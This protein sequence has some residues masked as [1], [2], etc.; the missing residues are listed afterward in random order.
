MIES[1]FRR[2]AGLP[3]KLERLDEAASGRV[4]GADLRAALPRLLRSGELA[5]VKKAWGEKLYYIPPGRLP[6]LWEQIELAA[7]QPHDDGSVH[8]HKE[9]GPG[10]ALDLFRALTWIARNGLPVTSKGT[11]HQKSVGKLTAYLYLQVGDIAGLGLRYPHQEVYPP[12]LAVVLDLLQALGLLAKER[13]SWGLDSKALTAWL[14]LEP[15]MMD[16]VL[17]RELLHRYIPDDA[18]IQ[19][20]VYRL[21]RRDLQVGS[22][23]SLEDIYVSLQGMR[24]LPENVPDRLGDWMGSWVEALGGFG[25]L[26]SGRDSAGT[27]F[28]RWRRKPRLTLLKESSATGGRSP[29]GPGLFFIQ[30]DYEILVPPDVSYR[31]RWELE[32]CCDNV[33]MDAMSVYRISKSSVGRAAELGRSPGMVLELLEAHS[34]GV[35]ENVSLALKQWASE[36]GRTRLEER[37]LLRCRD[38]EAAETVAALPALAG[39]IERIGPLDF[40]VD[41]GQA[42]K[43]RKVLEE[44]NLSPPK[45]PNTGAPD[46]EYPKLEDPEFSPGPD[47]FSGQYEMRAWIFSGQ[48]LHFYDRSDEAPG[49][50]ELFPG[51]NEIPVMWRSEMRD[52]HGSTARKIMAQAIGWKTKVS[53][54][55]NGTVHEFIP[56]SL[57]GEEKWTVKGRLFSQGD[58]QGG[59]AGILAE[60]APG[61]WEDMRLILPEGVFKDLS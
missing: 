2:F 30:P 48:D 49:V 50:E 39:G 32:A 11:I 5:A 15:G 54:R 18:A 38:E 10:L 51:V 23:Y 57:E 53:L 29:E 35:P 12:N 37:L 43:I 59:D 1:I 45:S 6:Q 19:H 21:A 34:A 16:A 44:A 42:A 22:W 8:L 7:L 3:F 26:D 40:I 31:V 13:A 17:F 46:S 14:D 27:T 52:Y 4:T 41:A 24:M 56:L 25:W 33:T 61:Q 20:A 36:M 55:I 9:A 58:G 47:M 60:I 28:I